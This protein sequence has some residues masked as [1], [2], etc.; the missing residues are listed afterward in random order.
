M[1]SFSNISQKDLQILKLGL[2]LLAS[3][4]ESIVNE[5]PQKQ[6]PSDHI[7]LIL[8]NVILQG[9][10]IDLAIAITA[11]IDYPKDNITIVELLAII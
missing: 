4:V 1:K 5:N 11:E 7:A 3:K 9:R 10:I 8:Q 2:R 6:T